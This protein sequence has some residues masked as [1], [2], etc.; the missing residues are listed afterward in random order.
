MSVMTNNLLLAQLELAFEKVIP[1]KLWD[2]LS[3]PESWEE[4]TKLAKQHRMSQALKLKRDYVRHDNLEVLGTDL[5]SDY[6][7]RLC[8]HAWWRAWNIVL[9]PPKVLNE[10]VTRW[11]SELL[12]LKDQVI[13]GNLQAIS[14]ALKLSLSRLEYL[15]VPPKHL[16]PTIRGSRGR[17]Q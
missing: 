11:T 2:V 3:G 9:D 15:E 14:H 6:Q 8:Y 17:F 13:R 7:F 4:K 10:S 5:W 12:S 16:S 1:R